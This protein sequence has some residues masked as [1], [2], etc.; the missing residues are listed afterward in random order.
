MSPLQR[1]L[2]RRFS[3]VFAAAL[4]ALTATVLT[5]DGVRILLDKGLTPGMT[6]AALPYLIPS[7]ARTAVQGAVLFAVCFV[8]GRMAARNEL[9][10][11]NASGLSVFG[12][13]WPA[14]VA[15][16][17]LSLGCVVL[18]DLA[19][20]WGKNGVRRVIG[21]GIVEIAYAQLASQ[22]T[23]RT[24]DFEITVERV[25]GRRLIGPTI[26]CRAADANDRFQ[27]QA[28]AGRL[29]LDQPAGHLRLLL[30]QGSLRT[31]DRLKISFADELEYAIPLKS[32]EPSRP[33]SRERIQAQE[34]RVARL[35]AL[36]DAARSS[37][38]REFDAMLIPATDDDTEPRAFDA[39]ATARHVAV[40]PTAAFTT[41]D[42]TAGTQAYEA[43]L[44]RE[45]SELHWR[46]S[47]WHQ[48]WANSFC[49]LAFTLA[50]IPVA[51]QLRRSDCLSSFLAC[52][53]PVLAV[54]QPLQ[55]LG[56]AWAT[57][58]AISPLWL[59]ADN[60]LF[61]AFGIVA[62]TRLALRR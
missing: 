33:E 45:Q 57:R 41:A 17:P 23:F 15:S 42:P 52:F 1:Q 18:E 39:A 4:I 10:A 46:R 5:L 6:A 37:P 16:I 31:D 2:L 14:V 8:Y 50:G 60:G 49:C 7:V 48:K 44:R 26:R 62:L 9:L 32:N 22:R 30:E 35:T 54:Y 40:R 25:E 11:L 3:A 24:S 38:R 61:A 28:V 19:A 43:L 20:S 47:L 56:M 59:H 36:R 34:L 29:A 55:F 12:V 51:V 27:A 21:E 53:L 58:G 13:V